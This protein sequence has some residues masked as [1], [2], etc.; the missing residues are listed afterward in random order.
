[1]V[2]CEDARRICTAKPPPKP[3]SALDADFDA[4][5][6]SK[7]KPIKMMTYLDEFEPATGASF[8]EIE[9]D[10]RY[11]DCSYAN[12]HNG[13]R[14]L[15]LSMMMF[16]REVMPEGSDGSGFVLVYVG[17]SP[18]AAA[19]ALAAFPD[20]QCI[21]YDMLDDVVPRTA[22]EL[23]RRKGAMFS[24]R[25]KKTRPLPMPNG[26]RIAV[27]TSEAGFFDDREASLLTR[28]LR[29]HKS[30]PDNETQLEIRQACGIN[31]TKL[32]RYRERYFPDI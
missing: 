4:A 9:M 1:M 15:L 3:L 8:E 25:S 30:G 14:K 6:R 24:Q 20:L 17:G 27:R 10:P 22:S 19:A 21:L 31:E 18:G 29:L 2:L 16:L 11:R 12:C 13:Q 5:R 7:A 26:K 32:K 28:E 23:G